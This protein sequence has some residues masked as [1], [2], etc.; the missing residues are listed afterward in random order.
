MKD[1]NKL[2]YFYIVLLIALTTT[3]TGQNNSNTDTLTIDQKFKSAQRLAFDGNR[4]KAR[5]L[6]DEILNVKPTYYDARILKGRTY[7]WDKKYESAR[8]ELVKVIEVKYGYKDAVN[9]LIDLESWSGNIEKALFYCDYGLSFHAN[10]EAILM[11]KAKLL[12]KVNREKE[13]VEILNKLAD[14][15][16]AGDALKLLK[17]IKIKSIKNK[18]T[19]N[20]SFNYHSVP[21]YRRWHIS[22]LQYARR[23]PIGSVIAK[24]KVGD[25]VKTNETLFSADY[26]YQYEIDMY[27]KLTKFNYAYVS[28]GHSQASLFPRHRAGLEIYQKL[29]FSSELSLGAR[30]MMFQKST[31]EQKEIVIYTG[32]IGKYYKNY[33]FSFRPFITPKKLGVSQSYNLTVRRYFKS[34]DN[35]VSLTI[36]TGNSPDDSFDII[37]GFDA[38]KLNSKKIKIGYEDKYFKRF[39]LKLRVGYEYEKYKKDKYR[40]QYQ[41]SITISYLF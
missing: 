5:M 33:W 37:D 36:G 8:I 14:I 15:N 13:A 19:L 32:S 34:A 35:F 30:Y 26:G 9:A 7:T 40:N 22:S 3:L 28:Y 18:I 39:L 31:G 21:Y 17:S 4:D 16:P 11:K 10:D 23:T 20:H 6:C 38:Y 1:I 27:P 24:V 41:T 2:K 29:P 12:V 25:I